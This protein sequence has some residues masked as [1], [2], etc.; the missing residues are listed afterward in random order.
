M[1]ASQAHSLLV[2]PLLG[3][4]AFLLHIIRR[5]D[6]MALE[7]LHASVVAGPDEVHDAVPRVLALLAGR[8]DDPVSARAE[9]PV[10]V[11]D[12]G[13]AEVHNGTARFGLDPEPFAGNV[14]LERTSLA[15]GLGPYL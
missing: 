3:L 15:G 9:N 8:G 10:R 6:P 5:R 13:V 1:L 12:R 14:G 4:D 2:D 7:S 11:L